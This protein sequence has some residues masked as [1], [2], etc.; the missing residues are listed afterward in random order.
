MRAVPMPEDW[1]HLTDED[2]L[3]AFL[4][5]A[6]DLRENIEI[7]GAALQ[8]EG[9]SVQGGLSTLEHLSV[10]TRELDRGADVGTLRVGRLMDYGRILDANL[11][12]DLRAEFG[13]NYELLKLCVER[14]RE[15]V[16][17]HFAKS[18]ARVDILRTVRL[19]TGADDGDVLRKLRSLVERTR[20]GDAGRLVPLAAEDVAVLNDILDSVDQTM[21]RLR[22]AQTDDA[23]SAEARDRDFAMAKV[24]ATLAILRE[25]IGGVGAKAERTGEALN[26]RWKMGKGLK[27]I[28]D[29]VWE[30]FA[31]SG[32]PPT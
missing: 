1:K 23:R 24:G 17:D 9:R 11:T 8:H 7:L 15:L 21:R 22:G 3:A 10:I 19:E 25:R 27:E 6:T 4:E 2:L 26:K 28:V 32:A 31:G 14:L 5:D 29:T 30:A 12:D 13:V 16:R 20:D 18:L